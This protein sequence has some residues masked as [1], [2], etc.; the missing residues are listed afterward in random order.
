MPLFNPA[1]SSGA[2]T[3]LGSSILGSDTATIT[4]SSISGSYRSL[5]LVFDG[6]SNAAVT[7]TTVGVQFNGDTAANYYWQRMRGNNATSS[8]AATAGGTS[9]QVGFIN[10]TTTAAGIISGFE[11]LI[12]SYSATTF[13]KVLHTLSPHREGTAAT[14]TYIESY[15]GWWASTAAIT[16]ITLTP[17]S[18]SFLTGTHATLYGLT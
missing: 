6:R 12:P 17:A 4:F 10:G 14:T 9:I 15:G 13:Q 7:S 11:L 5:L 18:G 3:E 16:S 1:S 2:L 8:A